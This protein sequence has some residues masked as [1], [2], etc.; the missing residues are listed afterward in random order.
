M[1]TDLTVKIKGETYY[2]DVNPFPWNSVKD[3]IIHP[4]QSQH[5]YCKQT[6]KV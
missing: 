5:K 6:Q 3:F 2:Y 1:K 4:K